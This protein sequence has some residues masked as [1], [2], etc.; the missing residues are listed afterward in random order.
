MQL[1]FDQIDNHLQKELAPIY[2]VSGE[3]PLLMQE[4][5]DAI[6][7]AAAHRGFNEREILLVESSFNWDLLSNASNALSL[8]SNQQLL[9]LRVNNALGKTGETALQQYATQPPTDKILLIITGKID[10]KTQQ[11]KWFQAINKVGVTIQIWPIDIQQLPA[12]IKQRLAKAELSADATGI[13]LLA[14]HAEGNLL[15]AAQEIEKLKLI[16]GKKHLTAEEIATVISNSSRFDVFN[17][18]DAALSG[19][20]NRTLNILNGLKNE[21][22]EAVLVLWALAREIRNLANIAQELPV[23]AQHAA[24]TI[25]KVLQNHRIWE[26]RKP[27]MRR[28]LKI[29]SL[30]KLQNLLQ[31]AHQIDCMIK[32]LKTG[33]VWNELQNLSLALAGTSIT[34]VGVQHAAPL[35]NYT[36]NL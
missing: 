7:S 11:A 19:E 24:S 14:T 26:K 33:N 8:F 10:T 1:R 17:L 13:Q 21:G 27:L 16:Y 35:Q 20:N 6:R 28:A 34:T 9:E 31:Q 30:P 5:C 12:W 29:H 15:A 23:G 3:V 25:E 36:R 22:V 18:V 2:L 32:G 4:T